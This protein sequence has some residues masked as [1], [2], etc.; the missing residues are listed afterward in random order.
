M[1]HYG[2]IYRI[3]VNNIESHLHGCTYVGQHK[4]CNKNTLDPKYFGSS[5]RIKNEYIPKYGYKGLEIKGIIWADSKERLDELEKLFILIERKIN[6]DKCLNITNGGDGVIGY[7]P[8]EGLS[9]EEIKALKELK[10]EQ[11]KSYWNDERRKYHSECQRKR[12]EDPEEHKKTAEHTKKLWQKEGHRELISNQISELKWFNNGV[13]NIRAKEK[14]KGNEWKEGRLE[15]M[16]DISYRNNMSNINKGLKWFNNGVKNVFKHECPKGDEWIE[17]RIKD[18][19][20]PKY[21]AYNNGILQTYYSELPGPEWKEGI[22]YKLVPKDWKW[23]N[24]GK[25]NVRYKECPPGFKLG[26]L[27]QY[28]LKKRKKKNN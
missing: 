13:K 1:E 8:Y 28:K 12:Y 25:I 21:K 19:N 10:S 18:D 9:E 11:S 24:N 22:L 23:Y 27:V 7:S 4:Y 15:N 20:K 5:A 17:G 2:Y 3:T 26:K 16:Y 14:P 6:S